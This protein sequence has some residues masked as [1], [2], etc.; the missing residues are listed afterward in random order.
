MSPDNVI[1]FSP[2]N[3]IGAAIRDARIRR[4]VP[5]EYLADELHVAISTVSRMETGKTQTINLALVAELSR[6]LKSPKILRLAV[7]QI[8]KSF[9]Q[10]PDEDA[11]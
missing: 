10:L 7:V 2:T 1:L 11:V 5:L 6:L 4:R 3:K 8:Q 9:P